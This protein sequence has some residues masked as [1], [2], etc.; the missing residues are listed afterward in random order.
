MNLTLETFTETLMRSGTVS[1]TNTS[2]FTPRYGE[3]GVNVVYRN[4]PSRSPS[5]KFP[6]P[7]SFGVSSVHFLGGNR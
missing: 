1:M 4:R 7:L 5:P 3:T 6:S 2:L